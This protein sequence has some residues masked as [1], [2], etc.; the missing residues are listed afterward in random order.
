MGLYFFP[1]FPI[2]RFLF[3]GNY[4]INIIS[5][6]LI[7]SAR[8]CSIFLHLEVSFLA[9]RRAVHISTAA[10]VYFVCVLVY[11]CDKY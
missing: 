8:I 4:V 5:D 3:L 1:R 6:W 9:E 2:S 10:A 11:V 7:L